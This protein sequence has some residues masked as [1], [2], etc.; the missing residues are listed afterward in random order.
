MAAFRRSVEFGA[1]GVEFDVHRCKTGELVVIHDDDLQRTTNGVGL[2]KDAS[3]DELKRLSAG[4]WFDDEFAGEQ[5]PLLAEALEV[6]T[7]E[8]IINIEVKNAP[9]GYPGIE[10]DL[11]EELDGYRYRHNVVVSSF[12]HYFLRRLRA[13]DDSISIG[14]LMAGMFTDVKEYARKFRASHYI[15]A[16]DCLLPEGVEEAHDAG[17]EVVAWTL[18]DWRDWR[19]A[20]KRGVDIICTDDPEAL[21]DYLVRLEDSSALVS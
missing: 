21:R 17:L 16:F 10:A 2:I 13:L 1:A 6:F 11:L 12:D 15:Q 3:L 9:V 7:E 20:V 19:E 8:M 14:L 18:N 4:K 5:I